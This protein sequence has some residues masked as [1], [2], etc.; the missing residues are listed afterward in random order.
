MC[1]VKGRNELLINIHISKYMTT[2]NHEM[3]K[4]IVIILS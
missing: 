4:I 1:V 2:K 3:L